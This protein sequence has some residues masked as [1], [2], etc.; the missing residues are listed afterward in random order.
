MT[1]HTAPEPQTV[2]AEPGRPVL[3][4]DE[5][6]RALAAYIGRAFPAWTI[7][8]ANGTWYA[9]G[10]CPRGGRGCSRTL[11]A[12]GAGRLCKQLDECEQ[13]NLARREAR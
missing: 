5:Q 7:W 2:G 3:T 6:A 9:T 4:R 8:R 1:R 12:P 11:H 13:Q 10:P